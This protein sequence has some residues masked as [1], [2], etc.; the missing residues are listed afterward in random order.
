M[1]SVEEH[2]LGLI[3]VSDPIDD[4]EEDKGEWKA[5]SRNLVDASGA[6]LSVCVDDFRRFRWRSHLHHHATRCSS[7]CT[8]FAVGS[9]RTR[10][11]KKRIHCIKSRASTTKAIKG[12]TLYRITAYMGHHIISC[13]A[14]SYLDVLRNIN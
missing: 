3:R 10:L 9:T 8:L 12:H 13:H 4:V 7:S 14:L 5:L 11:S 6:S 2:L 1:W